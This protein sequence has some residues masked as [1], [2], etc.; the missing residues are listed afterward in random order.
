MLFYLV[1]DHCQVSSGGQS[2]PRPSF[3]ATALSLLTFLFFLFFFSSPCSLC[4]WTLV[5]QD[6]LSVR[7]GVDPPGQ[8]F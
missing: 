4:G 2:P 3:R 6:G 1:G 7:S 8:G 5:E